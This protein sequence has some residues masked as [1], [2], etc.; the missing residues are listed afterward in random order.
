[1][2][3]SN[4]ETTD[5]ELKFESISTPYAK[6]NFDRIGDNTLISAFGSGNPFNWIVPNV[7]ARTQIMK[8]TSK[9]VLTQNPCHSHLL[10]GKDDTIIGHVMLMRR[11][12]TYLPKCLLTAAKQSKQSL[13][14]FVKSILR[15]IYNFLNMSLKI[16]LLFCYR[17]HCFTKA[18]LLMHDI[19]DMN[20]GENYWYIGFFCINPQ[21]GKKGFGTKMLQLA[22]EKIK[23]YQSSDNDKLLPIMLWSYNP[24]AIKL[25]TKCGYKII[26]E[27]N[28]DKKHKLYG[29]CFE[30][31]SDESVHDKVVI[32]L[33]W[34][35]LLPDLEMN[36]YGF[37][38]VMIILLIFPVIIVA[39]IVIFVLR[40]LHI[41]RWDIP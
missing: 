17:S 23:E 27:I 34:M 19:F 31:D 25:Y 37:I 20:Y 1:M 4:S 41:G 28:V 6:A 16:D 9:N 3:P 33:N 2:E 12:N 10:F 5:H 30:F 13:Y 26:A 39:L 32:D 36:I 15:E 18:Q 22:H 40:L 38:F 24:F 8:I 11:E 35:D 14:S 7:N 29:L 21:F